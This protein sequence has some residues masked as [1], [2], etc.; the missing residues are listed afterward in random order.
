MLSNVEST[1]N[2]V[3]NML[4]T[5]SVER[6]TVIMAQNQTRGKGQRGAEWQSA[7]GK[8]LLFSFCHFP[9]QLSLTTIFGLAEAVCLA[10]V[11]FF[12]SHS[13]P[14]KIKWPNDL[15]LHN[16]KI[17][18]ILL[19]NSIRD[20]LVERSI[21]G[22][23]LNLNQLDFPGLPQAG[24]IKMLTQKEMPPLQTLMDLIPFLN[25]RLD[26]LDRQ[27]FENLHKDYLSQLYGY[28]CSQ[29]Y[30]S[31]GRMF[32]AEI[33]DVLPSGELVLKQSDV[34]EEKTY[35]LKSV[36]LIY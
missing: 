3:A 30:E 29:R 1:S 9:Q 6:G 8:N 23:G 16:R 24:S 14:V 36:K 21:V 26:Q 15:L 12:S 22:I 4:S 11:D 32:S 7:P 18:G 35:D 34:D 20:A 19:E 28:R 10:L 25:G 13:I 5:G 2:Y 17:A 27:D 31:S 33:K